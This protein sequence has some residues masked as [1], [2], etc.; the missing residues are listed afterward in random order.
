MTRVRSRTSRQ[1]VDTL[2][3]MQ[4][5]EL[6]LNRDSPWQHFADEDT[7]RAAWFDHRDEL[8]HDL[9]AKRFSGLRFPAGLERFEA[10]PDLFDAAYALADAHDL[11]HHA[12]TTAAQ[13]V[14]MVGSGLLDAAWIDTALS[15]PE[16]AEEHAW[17]SQR[18]GTGP[19]L[20]AALRA[21]LA[22]PGPWKVAP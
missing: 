15:V 12:V 7:A 3:A 14:W 19:Y 5:F 16:R 13:A 10:P 4:W 22:A 1:R 6:M 18:T 11:N 21:L 8:M 2:D 20:A 9:Q 17:I